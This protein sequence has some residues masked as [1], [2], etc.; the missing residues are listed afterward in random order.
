MTY[1]EILN[2]ILTHRNKI[3]KV[4]ILSSLFLFLILFFIYP[5][6]YTAPATILPPEDNSKMGSLSSLI[7]AQDFSG[8]IT[9]GLT[10]A[11]SQLFV[12]ILKSR[13]A[14][15][16]VV[17]KHNLVRYFDK[18]NEYETT[19]Y[20]T[21]RLNVEV[22]KEGIITISVDISTSLI[23][24]LFDNADS[25]K[26]FSATLTN[27]F[28]EAL[29]KINRE[30]LSSKA[31]RARIYIENELK[32]TRLQLDSVEIALM[33]F[34]ERNKTVA[35]PEQVTAAIDAAAKI[36]SEIMKTEIEIG[37]MK[38]NLRE[39]SKELQT[40]RKKLDQLESQYNRMELGNQ[41]YLLAFK[42]VPE[43]GKE[44]A[45]LIREVKIQNEVYMLLQQQYYKERIQENR[46][47]PT[48]E[49]LD[50]AITPIR[51]TSPRTVFSTITGGIFIFLAMSLLVVFSERKK[52]QYI[53]KKDTNI[54]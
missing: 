13:S 2:I 53:N 9:G 49:V 29:D 42:E 39:D 46:D 44:L 36:K 26:K 28:S 37:L 4:T 33:N 54:V 21:K 8:L 47:L 30:K 27:S 3:L 50:K 31:K 25:V 35:L 18:E 32:K 15:E 16:Y 38:T 22:N 23:P 41:D 43:L 20:L 17:R 7:G 11:N 34:Q 5:V 51:K 10:N 45:T 40:L 14:A 12:E 52:V 48:V 24:L 6:T 1:H 19:Q